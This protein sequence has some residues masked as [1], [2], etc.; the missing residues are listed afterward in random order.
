MTSEAHGTIAVHPTGSGKTA[1]ALAVAKC[2]L[3]MNPANS[4]VLC[5]P[6]TLLNNYYRELDKMENGGADMSRY[7][8]FSIDSFYR[9]YSKYNNGVILPEEF[10][11]DDIDS[12]DSNMEEESLTKDAY[13]TKSALFII[14]EGHNLKTEM[15]KRA[16]IYIKAAGEADRILITTATPLVNRVADAANLI[17]MVSK[18]P[19][20]KRKQFDEIMLERDAAKKLV[21]G[22]FDFYTLTLADTLEYPTVSYE[23]V[24]LRMPDALYTYYKAQEMYLNGKT[25]ADISNDFFDGNLSAFYTGVRLAANLTPEELEG[26]LAKAN[27]IKMFVKA[28]RGKRILIY[29]QYVRYGCELVKAELSD[30]GIECGLIYGKMSSAQRDETVRRYN[31]GELDILIISKCGKEGLDLKM[32]DIVIIYENGWN[33]SNEDQVVGRAVRRGSHKGA[34]GRGH[35]KVYRLLMVKPEEFDAGAERVMDI[36]GKYNHLGQLKS[37]DLLLMSMANEKRV[38]LD[39]AFNMIK[40][41]NT[42]VAKEDL[43]MKTDGDVLVDALDSHVLG[44]LE[45]KP[46]VRARGNVKLGN[47][48]LSSLKNVYIHIALGRFRSIASSVIIDREHEGDEMYI[49]GRWSD[50]WYEIYLVVKMKNTDYIDMDIMLSHVSSLASSTVLNGGVSRS[51]LKNMKKIG[52]LVM[53]KIVFIKLIAR[54]TMLGDKLNRT[55]MLLDL[56]GCKVFTRWSTRIINGEVH[57]SSSF[58]NGLAQTKRLN[59]LIDRL[60]ESK[61]DVMI[62][63]RGGLDEMIDMNVHDLRGLTYGDIKD[64]SVMRLMNTVTE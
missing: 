14:D 42:E 24:H 7:R 29:S 22:K 9:G 11:D 36:P 8:I 53:D 51:I 30:L 60:D 23:N 26:T 61:G 43:A 44:V 25:E 40:V 5:T 55:C 49:R 3:S 58:E 56:F 34:P 28:N 59:V 62:T 4:I 32:T 38:V 13:S 39:N 45:M 2:Y 21:G 16:Q 10:R 19:I 6:K 54:L 15:G 18:T 35:V 37:V 63:Y 47:P 52:P 57:I 1:L 33:R 46:F 20:M 64:D 27:W 17:S 41:F 50:G 31:S 48:V 12:D